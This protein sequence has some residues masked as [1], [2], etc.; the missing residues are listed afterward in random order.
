MIELLEGPGAWLASRAA[1]VTAYVALSLEIAFGMFLSTGVADR[2]V[3]RARSIELHTWLSRS[4]L[5]L[6]AA[7]ASALLL[8]RVQPFGIVDLLLPFA[9]SHRTVAVALGIFAMW[10]GWLVHLSFGL[11]QRLGQ[12]VWRALHYAAFGVYGLATAHGVLAGSDSMPLLYLGSVGVV[13]SLIVFRVVRA[14]RSPCPTTP[15]PS[16]R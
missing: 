1:G 2:W 10:L 3:A 15:R 4:T 6:V 11:R 14:T 9:A 12:R 5:L 8:D 16:T 13:V 7:H